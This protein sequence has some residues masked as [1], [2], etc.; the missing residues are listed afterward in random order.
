ML[1]MCYATQ[2]IF[3]GRRCSLSSLST[4]CVHYHIKT[5]NPILG[6]TDWIHFPENDACA[7]MSCFDRLRT[8]FHSLAGGALISRFLGVL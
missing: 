3:K 4:L 1:V 6:D 5:C 2:G 7:R 8:S